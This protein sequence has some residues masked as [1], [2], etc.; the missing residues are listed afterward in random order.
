MKKNFVS[1]KQIEQ[2]FEARRIRNEQTK[3]N[4]YKALTT[5]YINKVDPETWLLDKYVRKYERYK[6]ANANKCEKEKRSAIAEFERQIKKGIAA[7]RKWSRSISIPHNKKTKTIWKSLAKE[8]FQ[9]YCKISR[10]D[11]NWIVEEIT[12]GKKV[13]WR[14][15][16]W[17]HFVSASINAT[18]FYENNVR[19]QFPRSNEA[20]SHGDKRAIE[21]KE[22]YRKNLIKKIWADA[23][24]ELEYIEKC[25]KNQTLI[26]KF[27]SSFFKEIYEKYKRLNDQLFELHPNRDRKAEKDQSRNEWKENHS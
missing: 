4:Y 8:E 5:K 24:A 15:T 16:Q 26:S 1:V 19:P 2:V 23:V 20:M 9:L 10:A 22:Q 27:W 13:H 17:W 25:W 21:I 14:E 3:L 7:N 6:I 11:Q 12:T 18:C